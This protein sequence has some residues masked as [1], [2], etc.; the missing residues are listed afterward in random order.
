M[1]EQIEIAAV[2]AGYLDRQE[3]EVAALRSEQEIHLHADL[4]YAAIG[5]LSNEIRETLEAA[6]PETLDRASR[7]QGMTPA[8]LGALLQFVRRRQGDRATKQPRT[9]SDQDARKATGADVTDAAFG[10]VPG[11]GVDPQT[12]PKAKLDETA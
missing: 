6:R 5:S 12:E 2:Y 9:N 11:P 10:S 1:A 3:Q 4:D 7:I 8:A